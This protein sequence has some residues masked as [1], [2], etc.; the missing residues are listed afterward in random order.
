MSS[1]KLRKTSRDG[2]ENSI[3]RLF[4]GVGKLTVSSGNLCDFLICQYRIVGKF[5]CFCASFVQ[6]PFEAFPDEQL[7]HPFFRPVVNESGLECCRGTESVLVLSSKT[8]DDHQLSFDPRPFWPDDR[9][10]HLPI[11]TGKTRGLSCQIKRTA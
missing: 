4:V 5:P 3:H 10:F 11:Q 8:I 7:A 9:K 1:G 6:S 2:A